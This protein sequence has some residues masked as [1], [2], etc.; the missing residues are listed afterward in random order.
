MSSKT[1]I[2]INRTLE[3][4]NGLKRASPKPFLLTRINA[5]ITQTSVETI[6]TKIA[7]YL[8]KPM[9]AAV[10]ILLVLFVNVM[11]INS[12]NKLMER[13]GITKAVTQSK[14]DFAINVSVM[15]D[16]ENQEP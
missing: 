7:F 8:K 13:E 9:I 16:T 1:D 12:R 10:A 15:Y 11:V 6:W 2:H 4:L 14:Y 3:S 5:A